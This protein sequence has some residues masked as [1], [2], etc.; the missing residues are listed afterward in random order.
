MKD[1]FRTKHRPGDFFM[2][3]SEMTKPFQHR[4]A[5][6]WFLYSFIVF[7]VSLIDTAAGG[8]ISSFF[9]LMCGG[10]FMFSI[11]YICRK[12]FFGQ[13]PNSEDLLSGF[14]SFPRSLSV[15]ILVNL[16]IFLWSLLFGIPGII[17]TY[18]YSMAYYIAMDNPNLSANECV[19]LSKHM[20]YGNKWKLFVLHLHYIGWYVLSMFTFGIL[21]FWIIP[22]IEFAQYLFYLDISGKGREL[23]SKTTSD[24]K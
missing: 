24:N 7:A 4:L 23:T 17:K 16:Y 18:S 9:T 12:I 14:K 1:F 13:Q 3:S 19:T 8:G 15:N 10:A 2:K 6:I 20:M 5:F 11:A 21:L 22:K